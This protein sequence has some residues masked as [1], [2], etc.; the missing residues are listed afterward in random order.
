MSLIP[1]YLKIPNL[2]AEFLGWSRSVGRV[3]NSTPLIPVLCYR[4]HD[5][6]NWKLLPKL[7]RDRTSLPVEL[8]K[9]DECDV[10][11]EYKSRFQLH[12]WT[13]AE[14]MAFAQHHGAPTRL[15]DWSRNPFVGLWFA[16][17]D[18]R[19]DD[20]EGAVYQLRL[21]SSSKVITAMTEPPLNL[22]AGG[23]FECEGGCPVHVFSSPPR[24]E[25][26]ERQGSVFSLANFGGDHAIK[27]LEEILESND[28]QLLRKFPVAKEFKLELRRFLSDI[29]LDAYSIYGGP[30]ALGKSMMSRLHIPSG[31]H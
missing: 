24:V 21:G 16:V 22:V 29:G 8:L 10:V 6:S 27:S 1:P 30:D 28:L 18:S 23:D 2:I 11:A 25:R 4:G 19:Y 5:C 17:S 26:T 9:Q 13:V 31:E 15:L 12:D 7:C 20:S 3:A 14:I